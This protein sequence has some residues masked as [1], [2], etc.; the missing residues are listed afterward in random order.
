MAFDYLGSFSMRIILGNHPDPNITPLGAGE[1]SRQ[2]WSRK[3]MKSY[4]EQI[5]GGVQRPLIGVVEL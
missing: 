5:K 1:D 4:R 3:Q 2:I